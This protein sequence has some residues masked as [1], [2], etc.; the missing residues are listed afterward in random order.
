MP[1]RVKKTR[2]KEA[3]AAGI[4]TRPWLYSPRI[5]RDL[6]ILSALLAE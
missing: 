6:E 1:V 3:L 2:Q 4:G 5:Y